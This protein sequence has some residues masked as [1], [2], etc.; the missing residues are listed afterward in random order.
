MI[1]PTPVPTP[2]LPYLFQPHPTQ[3]DPVFQVLDFVLALAG[4]RRCVVQID[5]NQKDDLIPVWEAGGRWRW[6]CALLPPRDDQLMS[7]KVHGNPF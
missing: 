1:S 3:S 7:E 6:R 5:A 2:A 4:I